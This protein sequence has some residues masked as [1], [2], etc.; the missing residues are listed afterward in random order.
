MDDLLKSMLSFLVSSINRHLNKR[1][2]NFVRV[3]PARPMHTSRFEYQH[4]YISPHMSNLSKILDIGSG[5]DPFPYATVLAERY[6]Q[7]SRHRAAEFKSDGKPVVICDIHNLPFRTGSFDFV[8]CS[9]VLEHVDAPIAAC[10]EIMRVGGKGY[11]ECPHFI[12]DALFSWAKGMH[13]WFI[14]SID[15]R[16]TGYLR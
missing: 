16:L 6:M 14:Q 5:G 10:N 3:K 9:H 11:I 12:S 13:K 7:P 15:N 4:N 2:W 8:Y 1:G